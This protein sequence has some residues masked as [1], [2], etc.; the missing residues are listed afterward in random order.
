MTG[1]LEV[2]VV[3]GVDK[4]PSSTFTSALRAIIDTS[5]RHSSD[6]CYLSAL[7][8]EVVFLSNGGRFSATV[9]PK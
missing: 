5:T 8:S 6:K 3:L 2:R 4:L 7:S 9:D 1:R